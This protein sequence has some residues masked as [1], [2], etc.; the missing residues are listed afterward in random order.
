MIDIDA[1]LIS[2]HSEKEGAA[3]TFK[4]G[5]GFH[6]LLAYLDETREALAG[7]LRPGNAGANTAA[8]HIEIVELALEQLPREVVE[9]AE[10]VVRT[11][12][13][14][15]THEFTDELRAAGHRLPDGL[16]SD[17]DGPR[18]DPRAARVGVAA[19]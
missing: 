19:G 13:A 6:P 18:R 3:G 8:D 4:G 2:A 10:I 7:V 9:H 1:T 16:R 17:R 11:D 15:A 12:S 14:A 5:F